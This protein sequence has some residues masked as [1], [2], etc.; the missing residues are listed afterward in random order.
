MLR[1]KDY[2][3]LKARAATG[4]STRSKPRRL[5]TQ[6][7]GDIAEARRRLADPKEMPIPYA[8]VRMEL[9]LA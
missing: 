3:E 6:D 5:T 7:R 8:Q 1:E 9:G 2:R 4:Q